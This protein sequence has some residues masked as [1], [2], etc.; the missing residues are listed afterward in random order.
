M[1]EKGI[2]ITKLYYNKKHQMCKTI[3]EI[4]QSLKPHLFV[5]LEPPTT[6]FILVCILNLSYFHQSLDLFSIFNLCVCV[7]IKVVFKMIFLL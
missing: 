7:H 2:S 5:T 6:F 4:L 3:F 1:G